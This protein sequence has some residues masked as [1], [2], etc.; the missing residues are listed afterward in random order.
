MAKLKIDAEDYVGWLRHG[1]SMG[2]ISPPTCFNH[3]G[4]GLTELE[5]LEHEN[6]GDPCIWL[7]RVY[8]DEAMRLELEETFSPYSWRKLEYQA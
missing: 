3:D 5:E 2:W 7:I 8:E 1:L 6:G 4:V